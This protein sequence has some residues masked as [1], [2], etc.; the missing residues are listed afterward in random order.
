MLLCVPAF[1]LACHWFLDYIFLS[2]V[3]LSYLL[4]Y[5]FLHSKVFVFVSIFLS[6]VS[7]FYLIDYNNIHSF[8]DIVML[9]S[10]F[11]S[12]LISLYDC[13]LICIS[14]FSYMLLCLTLSFY[15]K[16]KWWSWWLWEEPTQVSEVPISHRGALPSGSSLRLEIPLPKLST[17]FC[18]KRSPWFSEIRGLQAHTGIAVLKLTLASL[19]FRRSHRAGRQACQVPKILVERNPNRMGLQPS[20]CP[21]LHLWVDLR[22]KGKSKIFLK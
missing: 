22:S 20:L 2:K 19:L 21:C 3:S 14:P 12:S 8:M 17:P 1:C 10:L 11:E 16:C 13:T 6:L 18:R 5:Y 7:K 4:F 9:T 15:K